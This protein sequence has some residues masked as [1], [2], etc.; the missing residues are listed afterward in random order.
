[1]HYGEIKKLD[2]ANGVG[3]RTTLFVSGCTNH[4]ENCFQP[5]TW[6]FCYGKPFDKAAEDELIEDLSLPYVRGLTLLGGEPFEPENQRVLV[7]LL[8]RVKETYPAKDIWAFTGFTLDGELL[9]D[10]S[11]PRC[12][13]TDEMLG[14]IDV[15]VDG[16]YVDAL[17]DLA[18]TFRG[19]SNQRL[20]DLNKSR[21]AGKIILWEEE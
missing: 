10:G 11:H 19:S 2:V 5:E 8:R 12:E 6:D 21:A 17:R 3:V 7:K 1:M 14:M 15:L 18:L 20:I 9:R 13:V 4:C 16:R